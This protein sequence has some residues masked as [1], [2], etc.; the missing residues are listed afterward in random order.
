[1][2]TFYV[3]SFCFQI[4]HSIG[5]VGATNDAIRSRIIV[6]K[7]SAQFNQSNAT[8]EHDHTHYIDG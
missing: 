1:M 4:R 7:Q 3:N 2:C 6:G 8:T 5:T